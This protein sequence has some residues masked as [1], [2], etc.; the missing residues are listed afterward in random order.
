MKFTPFKFL[1]NV[2]FYMDGKPKISCDSGNSNE[3]TQIWLIVPLYMAL[4]ANTNMNIAL[5][6]FGKLKS[7]TNFYDWKNFF[8]CCSIACLHVLVLIKSSTCL[9]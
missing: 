8:I 5:V 1:V 4:C 6:K 7:N 3:M 2:H 9:F